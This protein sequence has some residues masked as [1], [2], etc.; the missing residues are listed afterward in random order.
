MDGC[1]DDTLTCLAMALFV[2]Q[3]SLERLQK[4]KAADAAILN[5]W[6][7]S[8]NVSPVYDNKSFNSSISM[9]PNNVMPFYTNKTVNNNP[10]NTAMGNYMWLFAGK[11]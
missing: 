3:Y 1:H 11:C 9:S 7:S 4:A 2:M 8:S 10:Y 6:T 5:A